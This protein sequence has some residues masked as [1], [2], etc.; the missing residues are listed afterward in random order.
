MSSEGGGS[1]KA[2]AH[3]STVVI[4]AL[5]YDSPDGTSVLP[6]VSPEFIEPHP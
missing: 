1:V 2:R 3:K 5:K 4:Y 6:G